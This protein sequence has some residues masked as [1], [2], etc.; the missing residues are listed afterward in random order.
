[1][2]LIQARENGREMRRRNYNWEKATKIIRKQLYGLAMGWGREILRKDVCPLKTRVI[3]SS[4]LHKMFWKIHS[5]L[6]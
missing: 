2:S 3:A 4:C 6:T 1:M 5:R